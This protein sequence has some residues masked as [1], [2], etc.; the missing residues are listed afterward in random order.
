[1]SVAACAASRPP[2][3]AYGGHP[4]I[5]TA[6]SNR[7]KKAPFHH[8]CRPL[9]HACA[10]VCMP[11]AHCSHALIT[12]QPKQL[13]RRL[14]PPASLFT[15]QAP[16]RTWCSACMACWRSREEPRQLP[17]AAASALRH[18][19]HLVAVLGDEDGVLV[20]RGQLAVRGHDGPVVAP[21]LPRAG[22]CFMSPHKPSTI[23]AASHAGLVRRDCMLTVQSTRSQGPG[24][25]Q[26]RAATLSSGRPGKLAACAAC[27]RD[28]AQVGLRTRSCQACT[29]L[30]RRVH[31]SQQHEATAAGPASGMPSRERGEAGRLAGRRS[32]SAAGGAGAPCCAWCPRSA[33]ARS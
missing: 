31:D 26:H 1:M 14:P 24:C 27:L 7:K 30:L 28:A 32:L 9:A 17:P 12:L 33:W 20:L 6:L 18:G 4:K 10:L 5:Y 21:R 29:T 23:I 19:Q 3:N 11:P 13:L 2:D 22:P 16:S 15:A 8:W 25:V